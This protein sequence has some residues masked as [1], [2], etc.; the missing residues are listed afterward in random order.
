MLADALGDIGF[1][2]RQAQNGLEALE[3][4]SL[5]RPDL[6]L[7]DVRMPVMDGIE[8]TRR[9][10]QVPELARVPIIAVSAGVAPEEQAKSLEAGANGFLKKPVEHD[11]LIRMIERHLRLDWIQAETEQAVSPAAGPPPQI[12]H[13]DPPQAEIEALHRLALAGDMRKIKI[14]ARHLAALDPAYE[15]LAEQI[16]RVAGAY[17]SQALLNLIEHYLKREQAA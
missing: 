15:P 11:D 5:S 3:Q 17:Q 4:A 6:I 9:I 1:E 7:M 8:A 13:I 16:L 10:R 12:A 14:Q 2:I